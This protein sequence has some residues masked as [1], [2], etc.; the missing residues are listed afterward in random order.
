MSNI[1]KSVAILLCEKI[2]QE[3]KCRWYT[4][5]GLTCRLCVRSSGGDPQ[6]MKMRKKTRYNGCR[7]VN[8]WYEKLSGTKGKKKLK[9]IA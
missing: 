8:N 7:L 1:R 9:A 6:K 2:R 4:I 5:S 3:N